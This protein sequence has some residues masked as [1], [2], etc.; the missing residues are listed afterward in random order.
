[1]TEE[2]EKELMELRRLVDLLLQN[3]VDRD[4]QQIKQPLDNFSVE[5]LK[6]QLGL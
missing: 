4:L 1:M 3:K 5:I 2:Q 6:R